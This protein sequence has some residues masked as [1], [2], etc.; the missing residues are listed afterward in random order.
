M[1]LNFR[2]KKRLQV[3]N[4]I[5]NKL[6][7][8]ELSKEFVIKLVYLADKLFLLKY[9]CTITSDKLMAFK[10]GPACSQ[11]LA[12]LDMDK[13]H[14]E[15]KEDKVI[16][17]FKNVY[18]VTKRPHTKKVHTLFAKNL[19]D[20]FSSLSKNEMDII[21]III[22]RFGKLSYNELSNYTHSFNEW[23]KHEDALLD[24]TIAEEIDCKDVFEDKT[25]LNDELLSKYIDE[26]TIQ[27]SAAI[28]YGDF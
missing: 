8:Q 3:I 14:V 5:F 13:D 28:Y 18:D 27:N 19:P 22:E 12:I 24:D 17:T 20:N 4:Y 25:F 16:D 15:D 10:R 9:G 2:N 23:K 26:E 7:E 6:N 21:D 11:T 1:N